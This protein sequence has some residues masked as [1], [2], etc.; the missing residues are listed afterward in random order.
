[1]INRHIQLYLDDTSAGMVLSEAVLDSHGGILLPSA[2]VLTDA[3]LTSLRRRGI[4]TVWVVNNDISEEDLK[5]EREHIEQ[6]LTSL[7]R[8][9]HADRASGALLQRITEYRL[10]DTA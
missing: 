6:R 8:R 5:A 2:A 10:G 1:M 3:M 4:D 9:C 7:F